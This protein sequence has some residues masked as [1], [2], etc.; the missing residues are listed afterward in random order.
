MLNDRS[1]LVA[2]RQFFGN[3]SVICSLSWFFWIV[4]P[5]FG[6]SETSGRFVQ[7]AYV[8]WALIVALF[9]GVNYFLECIGDQVCHTPSKENH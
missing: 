6:G 4:S 1:A 5:Y 8:P 7:E 2:Y 3:I 9:I